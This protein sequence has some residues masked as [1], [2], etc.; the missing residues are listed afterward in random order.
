MG[1]SLLDPHTLQVSRVLTCMIFP[2]P[3][4]CERTS[5]KSFLL[6]QAKTSFL[7]MILNGYDFRMKIRN[8]EQFLIAS[9][10][11]DSPQKI[12]NL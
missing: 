9:Q 1:I 3:I 10:I 7:R 6:K 2:K 12:W 11:A 4:S 8:S 5:I